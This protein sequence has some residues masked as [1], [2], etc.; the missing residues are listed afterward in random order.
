MTYLPPLFVVSPGRE[1]GG[2]A[3]R[4]GL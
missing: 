4:G 3:P 2:G 1:G